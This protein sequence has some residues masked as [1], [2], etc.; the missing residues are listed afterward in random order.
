MMIQVEWILMKDGLFHKSFLAGN[1][2]AIAV[3]IRLICSPG[4]TLFS[5]SASSSLTFHNV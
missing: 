2:L 5:L 3:N 1:T 4:L